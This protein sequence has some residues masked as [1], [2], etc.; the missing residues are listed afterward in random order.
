MLNAHVV[1]HHADDGGGVVVERREHRLVAVG[2]RRHEVLQRDVVE[3]RR[4]AVAMLA[5]PSA[6]PPATSRLHLIERRLARRHARDAIVDALRLCRDRSR[7]RR[8]PRCASRAAHRPT[9]L[10][11]RDLLGYSFA[12]STSHLTRRSITHARQAILFVSAPLRLQAA[13][14]PFHYVLASSLRARGL[15]TASRR[16]TAPGL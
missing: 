14:A 2:P 11:F 13:T 4:S 1:A 7:T 8:T 3:G 10:Q 9:V 12:S 6:L 15:R 16:R 5:A